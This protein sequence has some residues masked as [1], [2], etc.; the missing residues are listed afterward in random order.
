MPHW[1]EE[2][3][4]ADGIVYVPIEALA[5]CCAGGTLRKVDGSVVEM[6][7]AAVLEGWRSAG[8]RLDAYVLVGGDRHL[9][10]HPGVGIR[11]GAE[12]EAYLSPPV[13]DAGR[14]ADLVEEARTARAPGGP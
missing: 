1:H 5:E 3:P 9:S 7:A 4:Y 12:P 14:I 6:T 8:D 2:N 13:R 11:Y 10:A